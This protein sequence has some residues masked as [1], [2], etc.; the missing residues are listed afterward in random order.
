[1][2]ILMQAHNQWMKRPADERFS[3]LADLH[4]AVVSL[5]Q[6]TKEAKDVVLADCRIAS[7]HYEAGSGKADEP[8][9]YGPNG[10]AALFT[11]HS[12]GQF[13]R[14]LSSGDAPVPA[15][16]LRTLPSDLAV[17]NLNHSMNRLRISDDKAKQVKLLL[18][19]NGSLR[20]RALTG[21]G[22]GRIWNKDITSRLMRFVQE[23]PEWQPAPAGFDGARGLY[24]GEKDI[25]CFLV[26]NNR[27]IFESLP[28]GGLARGFFISNSEVGDASFRLTTFLYEFICGNHR[29][30]GVKGVKE[31]RIPHI[32]A[33]DER[34]FREMKVELI[35]YADASAKEDEARITAARKFQIAATK[36]KLLDAVFGLR[37]PNLP[38]VTIEAGYDRAVEME[39]RYGNPRSAWGLAGGI[40]EL[41]R[42][43]PNADDRVDLERAAGRVMQMAF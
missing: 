25:F 5:H 11:H 39:D 26:D 9:L 16:Y 17:M 1:M 43:L 18:S 40:T 22:Y 29:V 36:D 12:F 20:L 2:T 3:S 34:A 14:S 41:A 13:C 19:R 21:N 4:Q 8:V 42:E 6:I 28:G 31:L 38:R 10:N 23:R 32:G 30:W 24:A 33:A 7:S 15:A 27:R 37:I 35:A